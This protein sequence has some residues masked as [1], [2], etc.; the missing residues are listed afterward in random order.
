MLDTYKQE[1]EEMKREQQES[2]LK[3]EPQILGE[4]TLVHTVRV[5]VHPSLQKSL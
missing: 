5:Q 4:P 1:Q 2:D 3:H